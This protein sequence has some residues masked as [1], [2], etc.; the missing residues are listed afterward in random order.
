MLS[1]G[2]ASCIASF[3]YFIIW[4]VQ[5]P[6]TVTTKANS[7]TTKA[8]SIMAKAN[9]LWQKQ[10]RNGKSKFVTA[11]ANWKWQQPVGKSRKQICHGKSKLY[12]EE[13]PNSWRTPKIV[14]DKKQKSILIAKAK[15]FRQ[16]QMSYFTATYHVTKANSFVAKANHLRVAQKQ[17]LVPRLPLNPF[18]RTGC[19][20]AWHCWILGNVLNSTRAVYQHFRLFLKTC[21][22]VSMAVRLP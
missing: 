12:T 6:T 4:N 17:Q 11:K 13:V 19:K 1:A 9:W 5:W 3:K 10:I 21:T 8:N 18:Q 14:Q 16:K 7:I 15:D 2:F 20:I 22:A